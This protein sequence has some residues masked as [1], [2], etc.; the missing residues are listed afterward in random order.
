MKRVRLTARARLTLAYLALFLV[1]GT[2]LVLTNYRLLDAQLARG[3]AVG[4]VSSAG[5]SVSVSGEITASPSGVDGP[6][7]DPE[8][9]PGVVTS[10]SALAEVVDTYRTTA[11]ATLLRVSLLSLLGATLLAGLLAWLVARRALRPL[12]TMN[13][14][15]TRITEH[16]LD[17]RLPTKGPRDELRDLGE[18]FN[19]M[20]DRLEAAFAH[21]RRLVANASH[22][23]GTPLSNQRVLLEV[24]LDDPTTTPE[25]L[26]EV[27]ATVLEQNVRAERLLSGMLAMARAGQAELRTEPV[28]LGEA[29]NAVLTAVD[30]GDLEVRRRFTS[31][32]IDA[33]PFLLERLFTN[34]MLNAARHNVPGGWIEIDVRRTGDRVALRV[35]N[36]C[37]PIDP[38]LRDTLLEPFRR[39]SVD[40]T[41]STTGSGLGL[42]I[43][44]AIADAHGWSLELDLETP[45]T[46]AVSVT[47]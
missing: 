25:R 24:T 7:P 34:L 27:C 18:T 47:T 31:E 2:A 46:F 20:L 41:G 39:G 19:A 33:D 38:G 43:V 42:A 9:G 6:A 40:R 23:L 45:G 1:L 36:S 26:R 3:A 11:L 37:T 12:Q 14:T 21:E 17:E 8:A 44:A 30:T 4:A 10:S 22:E 35:S 13:D 32:T 28:G 5:G 16:S 15:A 29:V